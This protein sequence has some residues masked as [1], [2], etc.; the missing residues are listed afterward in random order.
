M[1]L[2]DL[3]AFDKQHRTS[4]VTELAALEAKIKQP[5]GFE[6]RFWILANRVG[7]QAAI[8]EL[9]SVTTDLEELI[10]RYREI[11]DEVYRCRYAPVLNGVFFGA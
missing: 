3:V 5:Y 10:T 2:R 7:F 1:K 8:T 4:Y 6:M 9:R 11:R